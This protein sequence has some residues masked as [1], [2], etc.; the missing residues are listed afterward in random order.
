MESKVC[1]CANRGR[2]RQALL[3][4]AG[5]NNA[6]DAVAEEKT[7]ILLTMAT[8]TGKLWWPHKLPGNYFKHDGISKEMD[9]ETKN[10]FLADRNILADQAFGMILPYSPVMQKYA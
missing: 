6:L 1:F 4:R 9:K 2:S 5:N 7:R 10:F 3:P 8:G